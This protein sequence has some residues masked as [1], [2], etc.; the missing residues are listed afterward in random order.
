MEKRRELQ[1]EYSNLNKLAHHFTT[2]V[3]IED[4]E[5]TDSEIID[6]TTTKKNVNIEIPIFMHS[7]DLQQQQI[8]TSN[9]FVNI[10]SY[11]KPKVVSTTFITP[12]NDASYSFANSGNA[13]KTSSFTQQADSND[14]KK[15]RYIYYYDDESFGGY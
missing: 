3:N 10:E 2:T 13:S 11:N 8:Q 1:S 15:P 9:K 4:N 14:L 7:S 5:N 12:V 6:L